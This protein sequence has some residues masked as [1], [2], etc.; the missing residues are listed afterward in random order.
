MP[1]LVDAYLKW[2][3][4]GQPTITELQQDQPWGM[5]IISFEGEYVTRNR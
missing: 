5:T 2:V 4:Y 1:Y 3:V